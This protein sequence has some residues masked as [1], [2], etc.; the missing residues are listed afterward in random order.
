MYALTTNRPFCDSCNSLR[1]VY[2]NSL[3]A[4]CH[5]CHELSLVRGGSHLAGSAHSLCDS[6]SR[7]HPQ[8]VRNS[9]KWF[10]SPHPHH[11]IPAWRHLRPVADNGLVPSQFPC[12][13]C[14]RYKLCSK[15][16]SLQISGG[17]LWNK[18]CSQK[19]SLQTRSLAFR[20]HYN[21]FIFCLHFNPSPLASFSFSL[22]PLCWITFLASRHHRGP[23]KT[24]PQCSTALLLFFSHHT[25]LK[26]NKIIHTHGQFRL[27]N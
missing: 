27:V 6:I 15:I 11:H 23:R 2:E 17:E 8:K 5:L 7:L 18:V 25:S 19:Y 9:R 26:K 3:T 21:F 20:L 12:E 14:L 24:A 13:T 4:I 22:S 16:I 1:W 10:F